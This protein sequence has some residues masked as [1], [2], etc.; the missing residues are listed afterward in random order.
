[1]WVPTPRAASGQD[2][3]VRYTIRWD[4][5]D[6]RDSVVLDPRCIPPVLAFI[7]YTSVGRKG[8]KPNHQR[9]TD[10]NSKG[11]WFISKASINRDFYLEEKDKNSRFLP[12]WAVAREP[13][14][15]TE[16]TFYIMFINVYGFYYVPFLLLSLF[17]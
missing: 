9:G 3:F 8:C 17:L 2:C 4:N 13:S 6:P 5:S 1:M 16:F 15:S 10:F 12:T 11:P 14:R 7:Y